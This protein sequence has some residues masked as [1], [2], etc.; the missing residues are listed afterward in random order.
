M[1]KRTFP[2]SP[3]STASLEPGDLIAV[4]G[5]ASEWACLQ[6]VDVKRQ[7]PGARTTFVAGVLPWRGQSPPTRDSIRGLAASE[8]GLVPIELFTRAGLQVVDQAEVVST[9]LPSNFR[10]L[11]VGTVH[12]VWGWQTA[13]RK[14]LADA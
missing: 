4:P 5:E 9:D 11:Q 10:D 2:F 7:G 3:R 13:M 1:P 6:V 14:A 8:H 12:K